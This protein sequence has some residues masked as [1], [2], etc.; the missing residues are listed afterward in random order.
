MVSF[1]G[2]F[3][4]A[5]VG[6]RWGKIDLE[7]IACVKQATGWGY[8]TNYKQTILSHN[9]IHSKTSIFHKYWGIIA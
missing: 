2:D 9:V 7:L 5:K 1:M 4:T 3:I 8:S 6:I